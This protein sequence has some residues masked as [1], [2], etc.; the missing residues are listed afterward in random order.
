M[1]GFAS[2]DFLTLLPSW[3]ITLLQRYHTILFQRFHNVV[4]R[5]GENLISNEMK[6]FNCKN[7]WLGHVTF[8]GKILICKLHV[9]YVA[10]EITLCIFSSYWVLIIT[11]PIL[12]F[13]PHVENEIQERYNSLSPSNQDILKDFHYVYIHICLSHRCAFLLLLIHGD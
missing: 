4:N 8:P 9:N 6:T 10:E 7:Y 13:L 2:Y 5:Y 11:S 1:Q 12:H 3:W